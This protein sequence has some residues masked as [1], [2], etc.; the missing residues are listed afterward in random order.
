[1]DWRN[2]V[3]AWTNVEFSSK[4]FGDINLSAIAPL[5]AHE[6]NPYYAFKDHTF[7]LLTHLPGASVCQ[8]PWCNS[9]GIYRKSGLKTTVLIIAD[10]YTSPVN[11]ISAAC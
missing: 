11:G 4:V 5:S 10:K 6:L 3:I 7:E 2:K 9:N 1:M 8:I